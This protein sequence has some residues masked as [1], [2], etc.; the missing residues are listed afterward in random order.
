ML[1]NHH[2]AGPVYIAF[3]GMASHGK[4]MHS[5]CPVMKLSLLCSDSLVESLYIYCVS[6]MCD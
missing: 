2:W 5:L 1:V 3:D 4:A 6:D